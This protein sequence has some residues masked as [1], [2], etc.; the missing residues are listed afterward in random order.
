V[1][2]GIRLGF[3]SGPIVAVESSALATLLCVGSHWKQ[4]LKY[5]WGSWPLCHRVYSRLDL[6]IGSWCCFYTQEVLEHAHRVI[7]SVICL[8]LGV[9]V[10]RLL[11]P[12]LSARRL[13]GII[14][15]PNHLAEIWKPSLSAES[16]PARANQGE[17]IQRD[18]RRSLHLASY[19]IAGWW[20]LVARISKSVIARRRPTI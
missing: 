3:A 18:L 9:Q 16:A 4:Q 5:L 11:G 19:L 17:R 14:R 15:P 2:G 13:L 7:Q 1:F 12:A 20:T 8:R 10:L 6:M